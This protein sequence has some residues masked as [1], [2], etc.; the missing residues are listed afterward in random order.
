MKSKKSFVHY[1]LL[2]VSFFMLP[3]LW[4]VQVAKGEGL[5]LKMAR[6]VMIIETTTKPLG[7]RSQRGYKVPDE[8]EI[9]GRKNLITEHAYYT[10]FGEDSDNSCL[11]MKGRLSITF[12]SFNDAEIAQRQV[13]QMKA[14]HLGNMGA[15]V[16]QA[17]GNGYFLWEV[18]GWYA[19]VKISKKVVLLED[20]THKQDKI[21]EELIAQLKKEIS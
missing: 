14:T 8:W 3:F 11:N 7:Y 9:G 13:E 15:K 17:D 12:L 19:A 2:L 16:I 5:S 18:N 6:L 1:Y 10:L 21:I 4:Q 20:G